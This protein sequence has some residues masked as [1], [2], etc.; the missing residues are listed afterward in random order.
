[1]ATLELQ[2]VSL[3]GAAGYLFQGVQLE[4]D[5]GQVCCIQAGALD[6]STTLLKC[7]AG[8]VEPSA[9]RCLVAGR[10]VSDYG[11]AELSALVSFCYEDGGLVSLFSVFENI[12]LPL[13]YHRGEDPAGLRA[14]VRDIAQAL[15]IEDCLD[16]R[17]HELNDVQ[18][19][20]ANLARALLTGA[21]LLLVDELQEGMS[22]AMRDA[23]LAYLVAQC[24]EQDLTIVMTTTAGDTTD[25][26]DRVF[27]IRDRGVV[28]NHSERT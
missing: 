15:Y 4:V 5:A 14:R 1:M 28:E 27:Q 19:R 26:A 8:I 2:D 18:A 13:V 3:A 9:G 12:V 11:D 24:R 10:P 25:F 16:R 21:R 7:M 23:V 17:V 6:G 22:P 20:L